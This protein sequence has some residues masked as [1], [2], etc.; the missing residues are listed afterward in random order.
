MN[1]A[2][3]WDSYREA[4]VKVL[5][6][7]K[8]ET[9][10]EWGPGVS[11]LIMQDFPSVKLIDTLEHDMAWYGKWQSKFGPKVHLVY[12]KNMTR[13]PCF[14]GRE[15]FYDLIFIDG[16]EREKCLVAAQGKLKST[17]IVII[18]DAERETY[19]EWIKQYRFIFFEDGGHTAI[20]TMNPKVNE[21]LERIF[22]S[23]EVNV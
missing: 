11:T 1:T 4:L 12:E 9:V 16:R 18:H 21:R 7:F 20:M 22:E 5:G 8:P 19:H 15:M 10:F 3:S 2:P 14:S 6:E 23:R 13:Y 17:G